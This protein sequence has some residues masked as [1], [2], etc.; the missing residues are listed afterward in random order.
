M[1]CRPTVSWRRKTR[2]PYRPDVAVTLNN[3]GLLDRDQNRPDEA[4]REFEE[5]LQTYRELAQKN[6]ATYRPDVARTLNNVGMLDRDQV[7]MKEAQKEY[8]EAL[9]IY[10][11]LAKQDS[12]RFSG[13]VMRVKKLLAKL[14][15]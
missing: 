8:A 10:E 12:Q 1:R 2:R 13:D 5:A 4:R 11:A 9:Q 15:R 3:L 6:P 7:R 14:P